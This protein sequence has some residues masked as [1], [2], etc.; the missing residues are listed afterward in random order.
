MKSQHDFPNLNPKRPDGVKP[1]GLPYKVMVVDDK[2]FH[3]KQLV[4]ILESEGYEI[5]AAARNGA[6]ALKLYDKLA[7]DLD[8]ITTDLDMPDVDG[9]ALLFELSQKDPKAKI[10]F[11]SED[12]TKGVLKDL[13]QMGAADYI[14][15][16]IQRKQVLDRI[17][18]VMQRKEA[19]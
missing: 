11:V 18:Q 5:I 13:L 15:K 12:T 17:R 3:R 9:Y 6:E 7:A 14:L 19:T 16:P 1:N 10:V 2:D 8:L 4:Q